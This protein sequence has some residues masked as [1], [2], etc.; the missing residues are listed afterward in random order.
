[1]QSNLIVL[2]GCSSAARWTVS[3]ISTIRDVQPKS[4][5]QDYLS[6]GADV[7]IG[8]LWS[9][10]SLDSNKILKNMADIWFDEE[11]FLNVQKHQAD[12]FVT[13]KNGCDKKWING[14]A[15]VRYSNSFL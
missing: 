2:L 6:S 14:C 1:M 15:L 11:G 12:K 3:K 13:F 8:N 5:V 7:V 9:V 10:F 4:I